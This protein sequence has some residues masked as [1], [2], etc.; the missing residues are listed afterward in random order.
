MTLLSPPPSQR[1]QLN[2]TL[3]PLL[4]RVAVA[5]SYPAYRAYKALKTDDADGLKRLNC[6]WVCLAALLGIEA[7]TDVLLS[8]V[9]LYGGFKLMLVVALELRNFDVR[10]IASLEQKTHLFFLC[11]CVLQ[12]AVKVY[13][14]VL[15]PQLDAHEPDVD[16]FLAQAHSNA[17][18][19]TSRTS[20]HVMDLAQKFV[21]DVAK[22]FQAGGAAGAAAA[23]MGPAAA[24]GPSNGAPAAPVNASAISPPPSQTPRSVSPTSPPVA[25]AQAETSRSPL[26]AAINA[27]GAAL[28]AAWGSSAYNAGPAS[29]TTPTTP[30]RP[31]MPP[32]AG[33]HEQIRR[34]QQ[35]PNASSRPTSMYATDVRILNNP[36]LASHTQMLS[37]ALD[38]AAA[39]SAATPQT[40]EVPQV[41][42]IHNVCQI[43]DVLFQ[44]KKK[45]KI[46]AAPAFT[47]AD[48]ASVATTAATTAASTLASFIT[49]A[50]S[51]LITASTTSGPPP[52][53]SPMS[54]RTLSTSSSIESSGFVEVSWAESELVH[55][56]FPRLIKKKPHLLLCNRDAGQSQANAVATMA[57]P[58]R[59]SFG[60]RN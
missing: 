10:L 6:Y 13:K 17:Q 16:I 34:P 7:F 27:A 9:P 59:S 23:A 54:D 45:N 32:P 24:A 47:A 48:V 50:A 53:V 58:R 15:Q 52:P 18:Q 25:P 39:R 21:A 55:I 37:T 29:A 14:L 12:G 38:A 26:P 57:L 49:V 30:S 20:Q 44:K 36:D 2:L 3:P 42:A 5:Y 28:A 56:D 4:H 22:G 46:K 35:P 51:S 11:V 31:N 60:P 8:W 1:T 19:V 41:F 40:E 33:P 43:N